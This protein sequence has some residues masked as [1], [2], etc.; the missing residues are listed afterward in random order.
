MTPDQQA[1]FEEWITSIMRHDAWEWRETCDDLK[2]DI[3][4]AAPAQVKREQTD[5]GEKVNIIVQMVD[6]MKIELSHGGGG[7]TY[8]RLRNPEAQQ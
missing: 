8:Q 4:L 1:I 6:G 3:D 7:W 5:L 2:R